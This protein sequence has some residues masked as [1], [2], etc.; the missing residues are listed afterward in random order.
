[1][2]P[3]L[4]GHA[5]WS[6]N[7]RWENTGN[8]ERSGP[9]LLSGS[10]AT[11]FAADEV[12]HPSVRSASRTML[13]AE[14]GVLS[15]E[16][17][18]PPTSTEATCRTSIR[19]D[20]SVPARDPVGYFGGCGA[21]DAQAWNAFCCSSDN[22]GIPGAPDG[23]VIPPDGGVGAPEGG[24]PSIGGIPPAP[25]GGVT[26]CCCKQSWIAAIG[27]L[28]ESAL[29]EAATNADLVDEAGDP[30]SLPHAAVSTTAPPRIVPIHSRVTTALGDTILFFLSQGGGTGCPAGMNVKVRDIEMLSLTTCSETDRS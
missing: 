29:V 21:S 1:M 30:L 6:L 9:G 7:R 23:G 27:S 15:A 18:S 2:A 22:G 4:D 20:R 12:V 19:Y 3:R 13:A 8:R 24:V 16:S 5:A 17:R 28:E 25:G 11:E 14:G 10:P 26:P